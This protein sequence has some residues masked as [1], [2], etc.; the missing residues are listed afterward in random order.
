[1]HRN[2]GLSTEDY[3]LI[4]ERTNIVFHSAATVKF[5]APLHEAIPLNIKATKTVI[6]MAK[7]MKNLEV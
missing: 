3:N 7:E 2:L 6:D 1:M 5:L 4:I